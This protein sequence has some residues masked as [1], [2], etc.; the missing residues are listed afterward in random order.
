VGIAGAL[1]IVLA[2]LLFTRV[3]RSFFIQEEGKDLMRVAEKLYG[4]PSSEAIGND[5]SAIFA[6]RDN[7]IEFKKSIEAIFASKQP[8]PPRERTV[9]TK[10]GEV[11]TLISA[12][13]P[14]I[15]GGEVT[16]VFCMDVDITGK[17]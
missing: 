10:S 8:T 14:I 13:F 5:L 2:A 3:T 1:A 4:I 7:I 12:M 11:R 16:E 6:T 15:E 17:K 9:T